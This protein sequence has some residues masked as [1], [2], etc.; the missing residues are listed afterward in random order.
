MYTYEAILRSLEATVPDLRARQVTDDS[1]PDCGAFIPRDLGCPSPTHT[2]HALDLARACCLFLVEDSRWRGSG[3]LLGRIAAA[4]SFQR[5]WQRPSGLV[6]GIVSNWESPNATA[7]TVQLLAP[8][9]E[10]ARRRAGEGDEGAG[11]I[12]AAL[13]E[14]VR[15]AAASI[16]GRGFHTPDHR[17]VICS[18]LAQAMALFPDLQ[19]LDYVE[20]ILAEGIDIN[21]DGQFSERSPGIYDAACNRSLRLMADYLDRPDL[22]EPVRANLNLVVHLFHPDWTVATGMSGRQD[23]G[24]RL[25][26]VLLADSFYDLARRD[27]NGVWASVADSLVD[28]A[29]EAR[30]HPWL[31]HPFLSR[32]E[33][34]RQPVDR[35]PPPTEFSRVYVASNL[36]RVRRG[37][38][39]ATVVGG[40]RTHLSLCCGEVELRALKVCET[41]YNTPT[42][43]TDTFEPVLGGVRLTHRGR[44]DRQRNFDLPLGRPVPADSFYAVQ[45]ERQHL[46]LPCFDITLEIVEADGGFDLHLRTADALDR[47]PFQLECCF[48]GPGEWETG[49]QVVQVANGQTAFLRQGHGLFRRG[50]DAIRIG[51]GAG[52]H[53][54]WHIR[55]SEP[56]PDCFRVLVPLQ[57]PVD[58]CLQVRC[59]TWSPVDGGLVTP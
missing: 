56:E 19:A 59:G 34:R 52:A 8:V 28:R 50:R 16:I 7:F 44:A 33:Y 54:M 13:G 57:T 41:F 51:P 30:A 14:Y 5:R 10:L 15:T 58:H 17:W 37:T 21:E 1:R 43:E 25:V 38:V 18:A 47:I 53:R 36:W 31:L 35:Q 20:Q 9:L 40:R 11:Q 48:A 39:S 42:F 49:G 55:G 46:S 27:G 32:P 45:S 22:L 3:E 29:G 12:A 24:Q 6:D 26:P 2:A 4:I 23:R